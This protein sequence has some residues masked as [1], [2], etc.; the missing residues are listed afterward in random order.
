MPPRK[1]T[2]AEE[3]EIARQYL[4]PLADGTW[5]GA[6]ELARLW[7]T[8]HP[9]IYSALRRQGVKTRD[10]KESHAFA[11]ACKPI[12][13]L[14][15]ADSLAPLCACGCG[16][17]T[18][19]NRSK[20]RWNTYF[21]GHRGNPPYRDSDWLFEQYIELG[22]SASTIAQSVGATEDKILKYLRQFNIPRRN[23]SEAHQ[24]LQAGENNP[25]WKGGVTPERQRL[26]KTSEW[27][28]LVK[29]IFKR[30]HYHCC[31]C[32]APKTQG[33]ILHAHHIKSWAD[34]PEF[35]SDPDNL[36]T[37]CDGCHVWVHSL[38]NTSREFIG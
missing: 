34:Y 19:W 16:Q 15:T 7:K 30:D 37:L 10:A 38:E 9:N 35:R 5:L 27:K 11:K 31:R 12:T 14:P 8:N 22:K 2:N 1:F 20:N 29:S 13:N 6:T 3:A 17:N 25:A 32:D 36:I 33:R 26:Y 4:T 21:I 18:H 28:Q 24:G 23:A